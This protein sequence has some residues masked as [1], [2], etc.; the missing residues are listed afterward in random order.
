[1]AVDLLVERG[2]ESLVHVN[3]RGDVRT[4]KSATH[5]C[6]KTFYGIF[7][8]VGVRMRKKQLVVA[9][10]YESVNQGGINC[11]NLA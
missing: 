10:S 9:S 4:K 5:L 11:V 2:L 3:C 8:S 1:M 6:E 7:I